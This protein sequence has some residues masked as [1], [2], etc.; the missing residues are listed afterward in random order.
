MPLN[1]EV[2]FYDFTHRTLWRGWDWYLSQDIISW[3]LT[4]LKS[5]PLLEKCSL[6]I[7]VLNGSFFLNNFCMMTSYSI[8]LHYSFD[9]KVIWDNQ[10]MW[11]KIFSNT[12]ARKQKGHIVHGL[13]VP[14]NSIPPQQESKRKKRELN[15]K[16]SRAVFRAW[17]DKQKKFYVCAK[18]N[19]TL[20]TSSIHWNILPPCTVQK[21]VPR[22]YSTIKDPTSIERW[23]GQKVLR[24]FRLW[25]ISPLCSRQAWVLE[26]KFD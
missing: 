14:K 9:C 21:K 23:W 8:S 12:K 5:Q 18:C 1:Y 24:W 22:I 20:Q 13:S 17:T 19:L 16:V 11:S 3:N 15:K 26:S 2:Q 6:L 25:F 7:C 4:A 10:V